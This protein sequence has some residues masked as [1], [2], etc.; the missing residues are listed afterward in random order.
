M[1]KLTMQEEEVM[2]NI[3]ELEEC[4]VKDILAKFPDPKPPYTTV[5]S[6]VKN[7]ERKHYVI[8]HAWETRI[9][10]RHLSAKANTNGRS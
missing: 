4:F 10:T 6:V 5:A 7:L 8:P 1:E 9:A 2:L 3:W